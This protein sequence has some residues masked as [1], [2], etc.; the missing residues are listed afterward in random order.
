MSNKTM[1]FI[2]LFK[3]H[4]EAIQLISHF[5]YASAS[6]INNIILT[7]Y[8]PNTLHMPFIDRFIDMLMTPAMTNYDISSWIKQ[9]E[10]KA[11]RVWQ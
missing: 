9:L 1:R 4:L 11:G 2:V 7:V 5:T 3:I 10:M 6:Y 8:T